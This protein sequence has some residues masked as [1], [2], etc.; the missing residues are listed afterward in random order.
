MGHRITLLSS[1]PHSHTPKTCRALSV[2]L[3]VVVVVIAPS[4]PGE[5]K[6]TLTI[7]DHSTVNSY[8]EIKSKFRDSFFLF[9]N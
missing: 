3:E 9:R 1:S 5:S 2:R 4:A 7:R 8:L 6:A